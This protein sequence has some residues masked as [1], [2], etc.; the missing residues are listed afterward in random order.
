[1][2]SNARVNELAVAVGRDMRRLLER[3]AQLEHHRRGTPRDIR[4][5]T[6]RDILNGVPPLPALPHDALNPPVVESGQGQLE[7]GCA[8]APLDV[9]LLSAA[10]PRLSPL[11]ASHADNELEAELKQLV[12]AVFCQHLANR[13]FDANVLGAAQLGSF[14]LVRFSLARD[15]LALAQADNPQAAIRYLYKAWMSRNTQGRG[16]HFLR[17]YLRLQFGSGAGATVTQ[18]WQPLHLPYPSGLKRKNDGKSFLTARIAI[19]IEDTTLVGRDISSTLETIGTVIPS[20]VPARL[21]P[22][23]RM[24][25]K[26]AVDSASLT[27]GVMA[28]TLQREVRIPTRP[29]R[30]L[31]RSAAM[32]PLAHTATIRTCLREDRAWQR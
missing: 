25:I 32:L 7:G 5:D 26:L 22:M 30:P 21:V 9:D 2:A 6:P 29:F 13:V 16:L 11:V 10:L 20:V 1:M 12:L 8:V 24:A 23:I 4:H 18:L 31:Q 3:I 27:T 19:D 28:H 14:N 15:G 17:T